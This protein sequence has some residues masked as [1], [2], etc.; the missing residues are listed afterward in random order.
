MIGMLYENTRQYELSLL[1]L[2]PCIEDDQHFVLNEIGVVMIRMKNYDTAI[3]YFKKA[4][5]ILMKSEES[6][7][8]PHVEIV[9]ANWGR[10]C[11][12]LGLWEEAEQKL[13][14]A[15]ELAPHNAMNQLNLAV[16]YQIKGQLSN[17][18][19]MYHRF[20]AIKREDLFASQMLNIA[21]DNF[22][23]KRI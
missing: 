12:H 4:Y 9:L 17:S 22:A 21:L 2:K 15:F 1:S 3:P 19:G 6:S 14:A 8:N 18:I 11:L 10:A 13:Q 20:L 7:N 16:V 5:E 23:A